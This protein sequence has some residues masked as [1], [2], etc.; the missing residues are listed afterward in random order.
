MT[1]VA[2]LHK[3]IATENA[4]TPEELA[5]IAAEEAEAALFEKAAPISPEAHELVLRYRELNREENKIKAEKEAIK[6]LLKGEMEEKQVRQLTLDGAVDCAIIR[7][8]KWEIDAKA[9]AED[10]PEIAKR[11][12]K[13]VVG[14]RFDG[15]K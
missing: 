1:A 7:T 15:K 3:I 6:A 12:T 4:V 5:A 9:L 8:T 10:E 13:K 11:Y 14:S 2:E